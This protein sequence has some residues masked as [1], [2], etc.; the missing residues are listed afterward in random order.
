MD[1]T[2]IYWQNFYVNKN[3]K[4][5]LVNIVLKSIPRAELIVYYNDYNLHTQT[6]SIPLW[7]IPVISVNLDLLNKVDKYILR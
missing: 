5:N 7:K 6:I 2:N 4:D 3:F 1:H